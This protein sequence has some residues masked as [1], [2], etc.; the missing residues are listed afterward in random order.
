MRS[1]SIFNEYPSSQ[2]AKMTYRST[3][4]VLNRWIMDEGAGNW[5]RRKIWSG[6]KR[7]KVEK[8]KYIPY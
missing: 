2:N 8:W 5:T 1:L 4:T 3:I 7:E 6:R